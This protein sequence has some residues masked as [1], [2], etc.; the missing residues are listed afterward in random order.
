MIQR[1]LLYVLLLILGVQTYAQHDIVINA[2]LQPQEERIAITQ[3]V[4]FRN[5]TTVALD[6]LYFN[7][8]ANS[9]SSKTTP[10]AR[11][12]AENFDDSF[13]F[14]KE[15]DR[16]FTQITDISIQTNGA[17]KNTIWERGTAADILKVALETPLPPNEEVIVLFNYTV[18]LSLIHI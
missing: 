11:R 13:H 17:V 4:T 12:F 9:F 2:K 8:W 3:K 10:L 6:T 15:E 7:D 5:T 16:G 18:H 1:R 14:E